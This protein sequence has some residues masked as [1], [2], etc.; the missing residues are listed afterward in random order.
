MTAV[1]VTIAKLAPALTL[2]NEGEAK[3]L[4]VIVCNNAPATAKLAPIAMATKERGKR[5]SRIV[6][7]TNSSSSPMNA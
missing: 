1:A 6:I 2:N 3:G 4:R 7:W 5:K